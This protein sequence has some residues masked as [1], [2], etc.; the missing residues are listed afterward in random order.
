VFVPDVPGEL[1]ELEAGALD[2]KLELEFDQ[3]LL[4]LE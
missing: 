3:R 4:R 1:F 2:E